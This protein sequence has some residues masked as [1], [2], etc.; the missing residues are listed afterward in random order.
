MG[1]FEIYLAPHFSRQYHSLPND[2]KRIAKEKEAIFRADPF[3]VLLHTHKLHGMKDEWTFR[4]TYSY[5]IRFTF[6]GNNEVIFLA[7]GTHDIYR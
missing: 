4:I 6:L 7:I 2:I 3:D 5:R 1:L